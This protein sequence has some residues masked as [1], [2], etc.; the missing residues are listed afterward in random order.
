MRSS[1]TS[2]LAACAFSD[3]IRV[4]FYSACALLAMLTAVIASWDLSVCLS[5]RLSCHIPVFC[6]DEWRYDSA[7]YTIRWNN[8]STSGLWRGIILIFAGGGHPPQRRRL[9][10]WSSQWQLEIANEKCLV[11]RISYHRCF[12]SCLHPTYSNHGQLLDTVSQVRDLGVIVDSNL[13]FDKHFF[14]RP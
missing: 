3:S 8:R 5:V 12:S 1:F 10:L 13:K 7:V 11:L 9:L 6:A 4:R 2:V 14:N